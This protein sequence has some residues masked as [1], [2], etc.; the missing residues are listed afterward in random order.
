MLGPYVVNIQSRAGLERG[1]I[2]RVDV[3]L[4]WMDEPGLHLS[5]QEGALRVIACPSLSEPQIR[6][7]CAALE[8]RGEIVYEG[9]R[10]VVGFESSTDEA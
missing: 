4:E 10:R 5:E 3:S 8:A 2:V 6:E 7:A 9:W 1:V